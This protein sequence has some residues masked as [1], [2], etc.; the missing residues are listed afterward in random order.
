MS[1]ERE[2]LIRAAYVGFSLSRKRFNGVEWSA[3]DFPSLEGMMRSLGFVEESENWEPVREAILEGLEH[4]GMLDDGK[5]TKPDAWV[6]SPRSMT[7]SC[8]SNRPSP[9]RARFPFS[10][11][12]VMA[13]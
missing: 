2:T 9:C 13:S 3:F 11:A 12:K 4:A 7:A 1:V 10:S 6:V 5:V 8:C